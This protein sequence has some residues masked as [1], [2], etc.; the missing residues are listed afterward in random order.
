MTTVV[1]RMAAA[2]WENRR[3]RTSGSIAL[4]PFK[5]LPMSERS[6]L[7]SDMRAGISVLCTDQDMQ[8]S[9]MARTIL[10]VS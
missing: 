1:E 6:K 3:E 4:L 9:D 10:E 5:E 8:L 2:S 7:V